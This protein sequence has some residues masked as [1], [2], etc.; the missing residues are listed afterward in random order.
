[1]P[2]NDKN[3]ETFFVLYPLSYG[4][5]DMGPTGLEPVTSTLQR[6]SS[7]GIRCTA[8]KQEQRD[9]GGR[10]IS[11]FGCPKLGV[12]PSAYRM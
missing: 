1:M 12:E 7:I 3:D 2:C 5:A 10:D 9:K 11:R 4:P 6:C 8:S